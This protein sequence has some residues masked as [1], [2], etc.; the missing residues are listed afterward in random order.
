MPEWCDEISFL[1]NSCDP[2]MVSLMG[3]VAAATTDRGPVVI[4]E[5]A[6]VVTGQTAELRFWPLELELSG[7]WYEDGP[8]A[9]ALLDLDRVSVS[10]G[11]GRT[12]LLEEDAEAAATFKISTASPM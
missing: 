9:S 3:L 7:S 2:R 11:G 12:P 6:A 10:G 8:A 1:T 5:V 4:V